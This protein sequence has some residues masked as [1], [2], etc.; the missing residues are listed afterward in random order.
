VQPDHRL[1]PEVLHGEPQVEQRRPARDGELPPVDIGDVQQPG[2]VGP[3]LDHAV[4]PPEPPGLGVERRRRPCGDG[5]QLAQR[6]VQP[7]RGL[8]RCQV[9]HR[10]SLGP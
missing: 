2:P 10:A 1:D 6:V 4:L 8:R 9:V 7:R 5:D 3:H